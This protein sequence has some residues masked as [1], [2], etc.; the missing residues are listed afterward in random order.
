MN[1]GTLLLMK[2]MRHEATE[3][4]LLKRVEQLRRSMVSALEKISGIRSESLL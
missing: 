4:Y 2:D 3:P 1:Y